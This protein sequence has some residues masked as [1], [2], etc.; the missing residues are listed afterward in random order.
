MRA[1]AAPYSRIQE[2][3][4]TG[5]A[6]KGNQTVW[7]TLADAALAGRPAWDSLAELGRASGVPT[8]TAHLAVQRMVA[9][10]AVE[11]NPTGGLATVNLDK[12]LTTLAATRTFDADV[13]AATTFRAV[14]R[15]LDGRRR[16]AVGG[17]EAARAHLGR[18]GAGDCGIRLLYLAGDL[19]ELPPGDEVLLLAMD[20]VAE[21]DWITGRTSPAQ[22][23]ADLFA[24][25]GREA[26]E[27]RSALHRRLVGGATDA[28]LAAV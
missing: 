12:V 20:P 15:L 23:Y 18:R 24:L 26:D 27:L 28:R 17:L 3:L 8:S 2:N 9:C 11:Q 16:F 10:G 14:Q 22:T 4:D 5:A 6:M 7:R 13:R 1:I 25:P 21:R 19:P